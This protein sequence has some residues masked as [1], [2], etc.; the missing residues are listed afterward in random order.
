MTTILYDMINIVISI[1][2][3]AGDLYLEICSTMHLVVSVLYLP[4]T[5]SEDLV[6]VE[7]H[8]HNLYIQKRMIHSFCN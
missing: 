5:F 6:S 1:L 7:N 8:Q 4:C 3:L 2:R